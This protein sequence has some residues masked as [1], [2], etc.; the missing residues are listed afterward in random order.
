MIIENQ[1][2]WRGRLWGWAGRQLSRYGGLAEA[3]STS[4]RMVEPSST[5]P[6]FE[7]AVRWAYARNKGLYQQLYEW[8]LVERSMPTARN[9]VPAV[10][11]FYT[12]NVLVGS[13]SIEPAQRPTADGTTTNAGENEAI[14]AAV[15]RVWEW[16]NFAML[17]QELVRAAAVY[18]DVLLKVA[19]RT[20]T[21][22]TLSEE[23]DE[24]ERV[25]SVYLQLL[26]IES[27][28]YCRADEKGIVQEIRVDTPRMTSIFGTA[29]REHVLVEIWRKRRDG[30]EG[31]VWF[32]EVEGRAYV[33]DKDLPPAVRIQAFAEL[34][35]D[36]IPVVWAR[37]ETPWW[38]STDQIDYY[39]LLARKSYQLNVP[40]GM[41]K[42]NAADSEGRP[43][44]PPSI[45]DSRLQATYQEVGNGAAAIL[46]LP[47]KTE[48]EWSSGPIDFAALQRDMETV[49]A[50][51]EESLPEYRAAKL[52]TSTQIAAETLELLLK[53]ATQRVLD[54][55]ETL[56][57]GLVRAQMMALT[58]GQRAQL[59]GF[60]PSE[61]G[62]YE[63]GGL[64]HAFAKRDVFEATLAAKAAALK[65][66]TGAQVPT[67]LAMQTAGFAQAVVDAYDGAAAE[68]ALRERMTLAGALARARQEADS[69]AADDGATRP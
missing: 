22:P 56:E 15:E 33:E 47:G 39:N 49:W 67:K 13:L 68:Q 17:K 8:G 69:G 35:Y 21:T 48:F 59:D 63:T 9:P 24:G 14:A 28:R 20:A 45:H 32:H 44:P 43:M 46:R 25:T 36:F 55:R 38:D 26:P 37:Y 11:D 50:G 6:I 54:M 60:A 31:G 1:A 57:R 10:V 2:G 23:L 53:Q 34:G 3:S 62:T 16:S 29:E 4:W 52:D 61:I 41:V 64:G 7:Y 30:G 66:L 19:E 12:S 58:L 51:I 27:V 65:A 5:R 18:G 40:L 42:A